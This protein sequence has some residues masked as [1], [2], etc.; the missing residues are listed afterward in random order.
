M[1]SNRTLEKLLSKIEVTPEAKTDLKHW[2]DISAA[3]TLADQK[4]M[5]WERIMQKRTMKMALAPCTVIAILVGV[6]LLIDPFTST[7]AFADIVKA[8]KKQ[9]WMHSTVKIT[10]EN[11]VQNREHWINFQDAIEIDKK[12][13]GDIRYSNE[14]DDT[15]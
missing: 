1:K 5:F 3:Y 4:P 7:E 9:I 11:D 10:R 12:H 6:I 15:L 2:A 14:S 13:Q 8:M